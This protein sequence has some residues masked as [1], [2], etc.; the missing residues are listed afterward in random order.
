MRNKAMVSNATSKKLLMIDNAYNITRHI[1][2]C[3]SQSLFDAVMAEISAEKHETEKE[4]LEK[5]KHEKERL[6][7]KKDEKKDTDGKNSEE[8]KDDT[9]DAQPVTTES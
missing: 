2:R 5:E 3:S 1:T 8:K 6:D 7:E 4:S 9:M